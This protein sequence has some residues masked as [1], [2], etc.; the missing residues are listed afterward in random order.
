MNRLISR[1]I[2]VYITAYHCSIENAAQN[3][4]SFNYDS[5][6]CVFN[7]QVNKVVRK[8]ASRKTWSLQA[9]HLKSNNDLIFELDQGVKNVALMIVV[10]MRPYFLLG[11]KHLFAVDVSESLLG[12]FIDAFLLGRK[13]KT[14]CSKIV[15]QFSEITHFS[16]KRRLQYFIPE[17]TSFFKSKRTIAASVDI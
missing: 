1:Y 9:F 15:S 13:M 17:A 5:S 6:E 2:R 8:I 4:A 11:I 10:S 14:I 7:F 12:G 16:P 3:K